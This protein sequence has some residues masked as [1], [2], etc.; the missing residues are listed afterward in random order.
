[1]DQVFTSLH[2]PQQTKAPKTPLAKK[3][4]SKGQENGKPT[5]TA[6]IR[7]KTNAVVSSID[8]NKDK[9]KGQTSGQM[10]VVEATNSNNKNNNSAQ[11]KPTE[12]TKNLANLALKG[13]EKG[14]KQGKVG[15]DGAKASGDG[16]VNANKK[17]GNS[18]AA[19]IDVAGKMVKKEKSAL[20][21]KN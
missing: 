4:G 11:S 20:K 15:N 14:G 6:G 17:A 18:A 12:K 13:A 21:Q 8:K 9:K 16:G 5:V 1:L 3:H 10:T 7:A 19:K 2:P